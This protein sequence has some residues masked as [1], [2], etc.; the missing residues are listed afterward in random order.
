MSP[1][2]GRGLP[3]SELRSR[4][5]RSAKAGSPDEATEAAPPSPKRAAWGS[6]RWQ[7]AG[8]WAL[9]AL[10]TLLSFATRFHRLD[11]PAHI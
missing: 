1:S 11:Q 3:G 7:A 10:V 5:G 2:L 9:V 6:P 4:R 8:R